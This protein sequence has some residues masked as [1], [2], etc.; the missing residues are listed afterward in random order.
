MIIGLNCKFTAPLC[1]G[2]IYDVKPGGC[3]NAQKS[4]EVVDPAGGETGG[5]HSLAEDYSNAA[6]GSGI[7]IVHKY[8]PQRV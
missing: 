2:A 7:F 8:I 4:G 5:P 6:Q 3:R 1:K